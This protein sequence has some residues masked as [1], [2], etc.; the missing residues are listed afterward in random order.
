MRLW[1]RASSRTSSRLG[2]TVGRVSAATAIEHPLGVGQ[3]QSP[4][5]E[6]DGEVVQHVGRL[7]GHPLVGLLAGGAGDLPSLLLDLLADAL[8]VVEQLHGVGAVGALLGPVG[9]HALE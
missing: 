1:S 3:A 4:A 7:L 5:A 6:E 9:E 2:V 8:G